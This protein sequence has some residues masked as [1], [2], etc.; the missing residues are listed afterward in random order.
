MNLYDFDPDKVCLLDGY[1]LVRKAFP[2]VN[3]YDFEACEKALALI[4]SEVN[5]NAWGNVGSTIASF[6]LEISFKKKIKGP[7]P[8]AK[9]E[10]NYA[11]AV[12]TPAGKVFDTARKSDIVGSFIFEGEK[13]V[14]FGD[15]L[16]V[17]L[18]PSLDRR[19]LKLYPEETRVDELDYFES[20]DV[21][22]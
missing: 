5:L 6:W 12:L 16:V 17:R 22:V 11:L 1:Y 4:L 10:S 3:L 14:Q 9:I 2:K 7:H 18:T 15:G 13:Y 21:V 19:F 20:L 8:F